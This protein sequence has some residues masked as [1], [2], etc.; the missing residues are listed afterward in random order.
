MSKEG[1]RI[2]CNASFYAFFFI[3]GFPHIIVFPIYEGIHTL[4]PS[5]FEPMTSK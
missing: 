2:E 3:I 5:V 4:P 1:R